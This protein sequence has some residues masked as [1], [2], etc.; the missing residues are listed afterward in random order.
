MTVFIL[1]SASSQ[2][3]Q[4]V[5]SFQS[6][7]GAFMGRAG[8]TMKPFSQSDQPSFCPVIHFSQSSVPASSIPV[9]R[10]AFGWV[11]EARLHGGWWWVNRDESSQFQLRSVFSSSKLHSSFQRGLW[12]GTGSKTSR[13]LVVG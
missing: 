9:S 4:Q 12:V 10:E 5:S 2:N 8:G 13:G 1:I 6:W 3:F 7:L 11:R